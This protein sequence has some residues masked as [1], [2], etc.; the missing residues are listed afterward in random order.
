MSQ[1]SVSA[2]AKD[3]HLGL[4]LLI[5]VGLFG[6][7]FALAVHDLSNANRPHELHKVPIVTGVMAVNL[8]VQLRVAFALR[9][10]LRARAPQRLRLSDW[11]YL[12]AVPIY[13]VISLLFF[14]AAVTTWI[15]Q[16]QAA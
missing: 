15:E 2:A 8:A 14:L 4:A 5:G 3:A 10:R 12:L 13:Q 6:L 11:L 16:L 9:A 7:G 1:P